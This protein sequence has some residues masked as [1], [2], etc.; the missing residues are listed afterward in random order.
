GLPKE[1]VEA[2]KQYIGSQVPLKRFGTPDEI[3]RAALFLAHD[4]TFTTGTELDIDGGL[5]V[6]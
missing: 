1:A 6:L 3:A 2:T 4:A 5:G